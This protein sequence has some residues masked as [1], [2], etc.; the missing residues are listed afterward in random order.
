ML[1]DIWHITQ[2]RRKQACNHTWTASKN[3][4]DHFSILAYSQ[5]HVEMSKFYLATESYSYCLSRW[6]SAG[7]YNYDNVILWMDI[8]DMIQCNKYETSG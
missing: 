3:I 4:H 8:I 7:K 1:Q 6:F 5:F 2:P